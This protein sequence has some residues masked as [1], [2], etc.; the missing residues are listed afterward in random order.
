M[1]DVEAFTGCVICEGRSGNRRNGLNGA[2]CSGRQC[3][4]KYA[5]QRRRKQQPAEAHEVQA[6]EVLPE[7]MS[8]NDIQEILGERCCEPQKL[9]KKR[10][11]NG[12]GT[13]YRQQFLVRGS[14]LVR[15]D[16][17]DDDDDEEDDCP[18]PSTFWVDQDVL[19]EDIGVKD[20][21]AALKK[22]QEEVLRELKP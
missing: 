9:S 14:F 3:I 17:D 2:T 11:K 8:V 15:A 1:E 16:S 4:N 22:R 6:A 10:R 18:E 20:V 13:D 12:P 19:L 7:S 5:E 21:K